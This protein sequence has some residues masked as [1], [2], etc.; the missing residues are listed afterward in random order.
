MSSQST[1][2]LLPVLQT[3][4]D[5]RLSVLNDGLERGDVPVEGLA[6]GIGQRD[7]NSSAAVGHGSLERDVSSFFE[8]RELFRERRV[9]QLEPVSYERELGPVGRCQQR[10]DGQ[11]GARMDQLIETRLGHFS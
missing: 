7:A 11:P 1:E 3:L 8:C 4:G 5:R 6:A 9:G 2:G 10:D